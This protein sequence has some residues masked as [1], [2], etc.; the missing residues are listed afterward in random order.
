MHSIIR[1]KKHNSVGGLKSRQTHTYR[2]RDTP[3]ADPKKAG[4]NRL[5]FGHTEYAQIAQKILDEYAQK[6]KIRENAVVAIEYLLSASP[7]FFEHGATYENSEKL[8]DWCTAQI[9]F[10]KEKHGERNILC[11]YLHMDEKTPHIEAYVVPI[12]HRGKLN[13]RG[14][15][16]GSKKMTELQTDYANAMGKFGLTR[17]VQG[18]P[19]THTTV[20]Q[21][22]ALIEGRNRISNASVEKA[23][24]LE[25]PK[26]T[27]MLSIDKF[28]E[29]QQKKVRKN[30][31]D[32]FKGIVHESK[33]IPLAKKIIKNYE[34]EQK[35]MEREKFQHEKELKSLKKQLDAQAR[36]IE[37]AEELREENTRLKDMLEKAVKMI[38]QLE[39]K[40]NPPKP[41]KKNEL[42][43]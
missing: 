43:R 25:K 16:G 23:V 37:I 40:I 22:Y 11:M 5:L 24:T 13:C 3:N 27:E 7:E 15:L 32:L 21:F 29:D 31:I 38:Q 34:K 14:F 4:L 6:H 2:T 8:R 41:P 36:A 42:T 33:L 35:D 28:M 26:V 19:A 18:S 30:V 20:K 17:G 12:D 9:D 10:L 39:Q 1:T